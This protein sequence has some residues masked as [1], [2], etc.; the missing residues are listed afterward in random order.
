MKNIKSYVIGFLTCACLFLIMG[1]SDGIFSG[2]AKEQ[3]VV[4]SGTLTL[5]NGRY[6]VAIAVENSGNP[7]K[8]VFETKDKSGRGY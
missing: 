2:S 1:Q 3:K 6:P 4:L 5:E 7:A 8:A